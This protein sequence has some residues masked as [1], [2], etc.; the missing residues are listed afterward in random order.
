MHMQIQ[1][2]ACGSHAVRERSSGIPLHLLRVVDRGHS[3]C[4][5][6]CGGDQV[7]IPHQKLWTHEVS[8]MDSGAELN[9]ALPDHRGKQ[10]EEFRRLSVL[11]DTLQYEVES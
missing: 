9:A 3:L 4:T 1:W 10:K 7:S 8:Y 5:Q 2:G 6:S 11:S